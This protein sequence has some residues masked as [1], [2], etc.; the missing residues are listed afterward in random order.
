MFPALFRCDSFAPN[1][2][3]LLLLHSQQT[4]FNFFISK[5]IFLYPGFH[6][7]GGTS[8][9]NSVAR[10]AEAPLLVPVPNPG[11]ARRSP[12]RMAVVGE[13]PGTG[14]VNDLVIDNPADIQNSPLL[15]P[16]PGLEP[17]PEL[18]PT[19]VNSASTVVDETVYVPNP[20][21]SPPPMV[22]FDQSRIDELPS[23]VESDEESPVSSPEQVH[24][25]PRRRYPASNPEVES[26]RPVPNLEV[27]RRRLMVSPE[28]VRRRQV[29][30]PE[31]VRRRSLPNQDVKR[32]R[33][34]AIGDPVFVRAPVGKY[35]KNNILWP[36]VIINIIPRIVRSPYQV[37]YT[38]MNVQF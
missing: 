37:E 35:K 1:R 25:H 12:A 7:E 2:L 15:E 23:D 3:F 27:V 24:R 4:N 19:P 29:P 36:G 17:A 38:Y 13:A 33:K 16:T 5:P 10:T 26:R 28:D 8:S 9:R 20:V 30:T 31:N 34:L 6:A 18:E 11:M 14:L 22:T 32:A 21:F